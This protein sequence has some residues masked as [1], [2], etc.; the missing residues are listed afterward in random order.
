LCTWLSPGGREKDGSRARK[1]YAL[2]PAITITNGGVAGRGAIGE[3]MSARS[4][5][6]PSSRITGHDAQHH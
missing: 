6:R 3:R 2:I 5:H 4:Y 1:K